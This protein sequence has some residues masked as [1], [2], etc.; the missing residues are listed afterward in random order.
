[1]IQ[2]GIDNDIFLYNYTFI[3]FQKRLPLYQ[4]ECVHNI[5]KQK[6]I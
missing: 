6:E 1:M 5:R 4:N 2:N 3:K